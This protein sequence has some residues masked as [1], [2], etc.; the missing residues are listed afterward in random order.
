MTTQ[1][2]AQI[3]HVTGEVKDLTG[4]PVSLASVKIDRGTKGTLTDEKGIFDLKMRESDVQ[5]LIITAVGFQTQRVRLNGRMKNISIV[6]EPDIKQLETIVIFPDGS[7]KALLTKAYRKIVDNYPQNPLELVGFYRSYHKSAQNNRYLNFTESSLRI[8]QS[9]YEHSNQDAQVEVLKLKNLVLP[10]RDSVDNVRYFGGAFMANWNDPVKMRATFLNPAHFEKRFSYHL[11]SI[12]TYNHGEDSV[13]VVRFNSTD[14]EETKEGRIWID[15]KTLAYKIIEWKD[16]DPKNVNPLIPL[17]RLT[18]NYLTLYGYQ[19]QRYVLKYTAI[20]GT[21]H[22]KKTGQDIDYALEFIT[23]AIN[24]GRDIT[25]IPLG[26]RLQFG[27]LFS[28]IKSSNHVSFEDEY[29][30]TELDSI[31]RLERLVISKERISADDYGSLD[32][33]K[34]NTKAK[35]YKVAK[36]LMVSYALH[37]TFFKSPGK[38]LVWLGHVGDTN[39]NAFEIPGSRIIPAGMFSIGYELTPYKLLKIDF[40]EELFASDIYKS[41]AIKFYQYFLIKPKGNPLFLSAS[42]G[43]SAGKNAL[44]VGRLTDAQGLVISGEVLKNTPKVYLGDQYVS[45]LASAGLEYRKKRLSYFSELNYTQNLRRK[46]I[47]VL[48]ENRNFWVTKN[49]VTD[50]PSNDILITPANIRVAVSPMSITCGV[51]MRL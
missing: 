9:G 22:N 48:R 19:N 11:E 20:K 38:G 3:R 41:T 18:R 39:K 1:C 26:K 21:N 12:S 10:H 16:S 37:T 30:T 31:L 42:L 46:E 14:R 2:F 27:E 36:R 8:Q 33:F 23:S 32:L 15:K 44:Y 49:I 47:L 28:E 34:M 6:L 40:V 24:F 13:Y 51:R 7:L 25:P 43:L 29:A 4:E 17:K 45:G 35:V 50:Y 5:I